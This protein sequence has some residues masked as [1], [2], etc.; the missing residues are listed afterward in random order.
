MRL[1]EDC[2]S[3]V[4]RRIFHWIDRLKDTLLNH[5]I[6]VYDILNMPYMNVYRPP[7]YS[8]MQKYPKIYPFPLLSRH[9]YSVVHADLAFPPPS[10]Y[11]KKTKQNKERTTYFSDKNKSL[12][13]LTNNSKEVTYFRRT[14]LWWLQPLT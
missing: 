3:A 7:I 2:N 13:F 1:K 14:L 8:N 4:N 5:T 10:Y 12:I 11:T 9:H 6:Y